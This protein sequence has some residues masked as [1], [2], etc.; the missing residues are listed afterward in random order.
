MPSSGG[1][2][3]ALKTGAAEEHEP[4]TLGAF[5]QQVTDM[6]EPSQI[7]EAPLLIG[8]LRLTDQYD[9]ADAV[10]GRSPGANETTSS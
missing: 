5:A 6:L 8:A 2:E 3:V 1:Y 10:R 9:C 4:S 7:G